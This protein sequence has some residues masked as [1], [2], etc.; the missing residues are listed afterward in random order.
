[1]SASA[2]RGSVFLDAQARARANPK[3][4]KRLPPFGRSIRD[5]RLRG[6]VPATMIVVGLDTWDYGKAH[7]RCV[8]PIDFDPSD[9]NFDFIAGLDTAVVRIPSLTTLERRDHALRA[10]LAC[11]P[12]SLRCIE[13]TD[14][15][16]WLW[17]KSRKHGLEKPEYLQ[18]Q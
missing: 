3:A 6:L 9:F 16:E 12:I 4:G 5:L 8:I 2:E 1:M 17:V 15:I 13:M 10:L 11:D 7:A 18:C 14:P